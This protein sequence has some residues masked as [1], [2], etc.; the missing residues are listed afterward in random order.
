MKYCAEKYGN[1]RG[2]LQK[3]CRPGDDKNDKIDVLGMLLAVLTG[4]LLFWGM[5]LFFFEVVYLHKY[6]YPS[7][8]TWQVLLARPDMLLV[9]SPALNLLLLALR[10]R[11]RSAQRYARLTQAAVLLVVVSA[12]IIAVGSALFWPYCETLP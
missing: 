4:L 8:H 6:T 10:G 3:Q 7:P 2:W 12:V 1:L 5:H 9:L 11:C